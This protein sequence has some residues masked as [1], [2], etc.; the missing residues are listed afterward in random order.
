MTQT[1]VN[2][3]ASS[4]TQEEAFFVLL[5]RTPQALFCQSSGVT[6]P[7][8]IIGFVRKWYGAYMTPAASGCAKNIAER[9]GRLVIEPTVQVHH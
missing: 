2:R 6:T 3:N 1:V 9:F 4:S 8:S 5:L 7:L